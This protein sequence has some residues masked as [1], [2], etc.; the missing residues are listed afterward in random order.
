MRTK[1]IACTFYV[2]VH[3]F[4][5]GEHPGGAIKVDSSQNLCTLFIFFTIDVILKEAFPQY[6]V[7]FIKG[8]HVLPDGTDCKIC[9]FLVFFS[10]NRFDCSGER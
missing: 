6:C 3:F 9:H 7:S 1:L 5:L 8:V 4:A 10:T 2:N